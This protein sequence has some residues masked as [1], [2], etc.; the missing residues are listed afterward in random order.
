MATINRQK[1]QNLCDNDYTMKILESYLSMNY[2]Q[3]EKN[4]KCFTL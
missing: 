2:R 4:K 1:L 3:V